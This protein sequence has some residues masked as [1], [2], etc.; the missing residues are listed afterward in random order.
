[1]KENIHTIHINQDMALK[2]AFSYIY[3]CHDL[4]LKPLESTFCALQTSILVSEVLYSPYLAAT[5]N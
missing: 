5:L 4:N 1:M 3:P 2:L